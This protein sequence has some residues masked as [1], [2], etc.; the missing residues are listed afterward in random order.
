[1]I[2]LTGVFYPNPKKLRIQ[3]FWVSRIGSNKIRILWRPQYTSNPMLESSWG[4]GESVISPNAPHVH[5]VHSGSALRF[6][7]KTLSL[8]IHE[9]SF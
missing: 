2:I 9:D 7:F 4:L 1:M 6:S 5:L 8:N 3:T